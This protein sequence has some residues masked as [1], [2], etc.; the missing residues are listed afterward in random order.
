MTQ[1]EALAVAAAIVTVHGG[2]CWYCSMEAVESL[3]K[4]LPKF[5][6]RELMNEQ[7]KEAAVHGRHYAT[8][9]AR[10]D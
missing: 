7:F 2:K 6:W 5:D 4:S 1:E 9:G 3:Q 10:Q 8:K